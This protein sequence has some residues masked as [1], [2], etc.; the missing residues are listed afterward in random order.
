ME[1]E[2]ETNI[3]DESAVLTGFEDDVGSLT[4][5]AHGSEQDD[6]NSNGELKV[7]DEIAEYEEV[8]VSMAAGKEIL[9][10]L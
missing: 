4:T 2:G 6:N 1:L 10:F 7:Q 3:D 9:S 8:S 5:P